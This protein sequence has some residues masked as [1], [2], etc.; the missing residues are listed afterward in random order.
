MECS[1]FFACFSLFSFVSP[2]H[3]SFWL[4]NFQTCPLS[5]LA[6]SS[7]CVVTSAQ[8]LRERDRSI[9][10]SWR[11]EQAVRVLGVQWGKRRHDY[12]E[13]VNKFKLNF[14]RHETRCIRVFCLCSWASA[15]GIARIIVWFWGEPMQYDIH[16]RVPR[17]SSEYQRKQSASLLFSLHV[18]FAIN[19]MHHVFVLD[20]IHWQ[21]MHQFLIPV[22]LPV[23]MATINIYKPLATLV[24][25]QRI[26]IIQQPSFCR[27]RQWKQNTDNLLD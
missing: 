11:F 4:V 10:G 14:W 17:I 16:V 22:N 2:S 26:F 18:W 7:V 5:P 15:R 24:F 21:A 12:N 27:Y 25:I 1:S 3:C 9:R 8:E 6:H 19:K 23:V 13:P 20:A